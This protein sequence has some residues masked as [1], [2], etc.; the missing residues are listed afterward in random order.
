VWIYNA[1]I[2]AILMV[3]LGH[4]VVD[5]FEKAQL[6]SL[7]WWVDCVILVM[8]RWSVPLFVMISGALLLDPAKKESFGDFYRKRASRILVPLLF[9]SAVYTVWTALRE[10]RQPAGWSFG[11]LVENLLNGVPYYHLWYVYMLLFLYLFT[12]FYRLVVAGATRA[13]LRFLVAVGFAMICTSLA[14]E[15]FTH[16]TPDLFIGGFIAFTPYFFLGHLLHTSR[17]RP[18]TILLVLAALAAVAFGAVGAFVVTRTY[19]A[20]A[21]GYFYTF[22]S[23]PVVVLAVCVLFLVKKVDRPLL[24]TEWTLLLGTSTFGM[25]L[26]H[27]GVLDV[28]RFVGLRIGITNPFV[29]TIALTVPTFVV[30]AGIVLAFRKTPWLRRTI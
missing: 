28:V 20:Q 15:Q 7:N 5:D 25:Y 30:S 26:V 2:V 29:L 21:A 4:S 13:Q 3:V 18:N 11:Q 1:R 17:V 27:A 14:H 16:G 12:P 19:G 9:W 6:G 8:R 24:G 23:L 22:L 10:S